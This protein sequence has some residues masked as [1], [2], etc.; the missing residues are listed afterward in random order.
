MSLAEKIDASSTDIHAIA[1]YLDGLDG[2]RRWDE[3]S[4]LGRD[5]QRTLWEK[6]AQAKPL[7]L[8]YFVGEAAPRTE[9]IHDGINTLPL[10]T[11]LR[12][13]QKRFARPLP[14]GHAPRLFGYNEGPTRQLVG[15]GFFV[16]IP[17]KGTPT[18][19]SRGA[20]VVD[21]WQVPDGEVPSGW[22]K[23]VP[24]DW[25][26]QKLVYFQTRDFMRRVSKHVSIGAAFKKEKP[27]DHYFVL[28]RRD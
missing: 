3:V 7:E 21:Y 2:S 23:I 24:N 28:C 13:F 18:W 9:V 19:E 26:L 5:R 17:T 6:A 20:V 8:A 27:L 4:R 25:R 12:R 22:P 14:N 16:T 15:P 1:D 11:P 10:P